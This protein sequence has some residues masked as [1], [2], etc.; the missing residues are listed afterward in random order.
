LFK[1]FITKKFLHSFSQR[2]VSALSRAIFRLITYFF[3]R[4][5]IRLAMLIVWFALQSYVRTS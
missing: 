3:A 2:H 1:V 4:H 5:T